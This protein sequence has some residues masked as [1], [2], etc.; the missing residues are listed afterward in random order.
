MNNDN[1]INV[2]IL[3]CTILCKIKHWV[4][5]F[6]CSFIKYPPPQV[7][8]YRTTVRVSANNLF[9]ILEDYARATEN[10]CSVEI[11]QF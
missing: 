8:N 9:N 10:V 3:N 7:P 4:I 11:L 1:V 2:L 5:L 6:F